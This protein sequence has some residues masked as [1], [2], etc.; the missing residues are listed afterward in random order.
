M[1]S[2]DMSKEDENKKKGSGAL[3][4][5]STSGGKSNFL[6]SFMRERQKIDRIYE[7]IR[8][9]H[10]NKSAISSQDKATK[11]ECRSAHSLG[12]NT[13]SKR[14][15]RSNFLVDIHL[16]DRA[17]FGDG[18]GSWWDR[19][20]NC[21]PP[22]TSSFSSG[23]VE[24]KRGFKSHMPGK[25]VISRDA[26]NVKKKE[27]SISHARQDK[28]SVEDLTSASDKKLVFLSK[29]NNSRRLDVKPKP[30]EGTELTLE[31][32]S[33]E[34]A[35]EKAIEFAKLVEQSTKR[36]LLRARHPE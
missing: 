35:K 33:T 4:S 9:S 28:S 34:A 29:M 20:L 23:F 22:N 6:E 13:S 19:W 30:M 5:A 26:S 31:S 36:L 17:R 3:T 15:V 24:P 25:Y 2:I 27:R 11:V 10:T 1:N 21:K 16:G 18:D 7:N 8:R 12:D 32:F 14:E